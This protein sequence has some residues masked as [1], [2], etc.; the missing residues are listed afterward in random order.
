MTN[1]IDTMIQLLIGAAETHGHINVISGPT[2]HHSPAIFYVIIA[3][4]KSNETTDSWNLTTCPT[5]QRELQAFLLPVQQWAEQ[6]ACM[7]ERN[8]IAFHVATL[9]D[10]ERVTGFNFF[11]ELP[12]ED[13]LNLLSRTAIDSTLV[14]NPARS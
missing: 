13:K 4:A 2:R 10:V 11:P 14:I 6:E 9:L 5:D 3:C 12:V 7:S 1:V 8:W